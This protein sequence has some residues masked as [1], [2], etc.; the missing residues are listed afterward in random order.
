MTTITATPGMHKPH[1]AAVRA[2]MAGNYPA[3]AK[4][5]KRRAG[6]LPGKPAPI[7]NSPTSQRIEQI[8]KEDRSERVVKSVTP[9]FPTTIADAVQRFHKQLKPEE[10]ATLSYFLESAEGLQSSRGLTA[11]YSGISVDQSQSDFCHITDRT[12]R[13]REEFQRV[14]TGMGKNFQRVAMELILE[15]PVEGEA[16]R[17]HTVVGREL[18]GYADD[19]R[20]L[21]GVVTALRCLSWCISELMAGGKAPVRGCHA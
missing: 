19:R 7:D 10:I 8:A 2:I 18:T 11:S 12:R 4:P 21:G 20:A 1:A 13:Q 9:P 5:K 14:W 6:N 17:A 15:Q 16:P 3:R